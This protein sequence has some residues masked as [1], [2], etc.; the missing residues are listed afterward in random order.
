MVAFI[1]IW[2]TFKVFSKKRT[3]LCCSR[4]VSYMFNRMSRNP[5]PPPRH[6]IWSNTVLLRPNRSQS[7][8]PRGRPH[9]VIHNLRSSNNTGAC[10]YFYVA[11]IP[12]GTCSMVDSPTCTYFCL[13][14]VGETA[15]MGGG[16]RGGVWG[17]LLV[18]KDQLCEI[19][20]VEQVRRN[21]FRGFPV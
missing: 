8:R 14:M 7:K 4:C 18:F 6:S 13:Y 19:E 3:P 11:T 5:P 15:G 12:H 1:L 2:M 10:H 9:A 17:C 21:P 20:G 16:G